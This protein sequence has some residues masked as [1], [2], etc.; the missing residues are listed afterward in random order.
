A[1][2]FVPKRIHAYGEAMVRVAGAAIGSWRDGQA[3]NLHQDLSRVTMEVVAEVLFG[4]GM[5]AEDVH[6]VRESMETVNE[7]FANSPEAILKVRGWV[8]TPR[9]LAT[10]RAV[11]RIDELVYRIIAGRR[12]GEPRDDL[13]GTLLAAKDDDGA[14]MSDQQLRDEV[15]TLFLAG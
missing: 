3:V 11:R 5:A 6:A 15:I 1:Q 14:R 7:F 12:A 10:S 13:L 9:N 8:P 2:A 4:T